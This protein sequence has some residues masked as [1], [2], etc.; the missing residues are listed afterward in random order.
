MKRDILCTDCGQHFLELFSQ[1]DKLEKEIGEEV[2]LISGRSIKNHEMHC[3]TC[4]ATIR[5]HDRCVALSISKKNFPY[6]E[7]ESDY[8]AFDDKLRVKFA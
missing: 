5:Q 2:R 4:F 1:P 7:W 3:D 8:I 6:S